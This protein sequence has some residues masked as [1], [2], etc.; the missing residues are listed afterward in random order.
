MN[1]SSFIN[2]RSNKYKRKRIQSSLVL[3]DTG[4]IDDEAEIL[5]ENRSIK[6]DTFKYITSLPFVPTNRY[7]ITYT[8]I[9]L[10]LVCV[11]TYFN[12]FIVEHVFI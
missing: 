1:S 12:L 10:L 5:N 11:F 9:F 7:S 3:N 2:N 8:L 4:D 6:F